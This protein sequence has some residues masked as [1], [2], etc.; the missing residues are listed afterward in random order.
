MPKA[1]VPFP[2]TVTA[3]EAF[4]SQVGAYRGTVYFTSSDTA[5]LPP[6]YT[7]TSTDG[8]PQTVTA[9]D[10][11]HAAV[12]G[13]GHVPAQAAAAFDSLALNGFGGG[14]WTRSR[15]DAFFTEEQRELGGAFI[16]RR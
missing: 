2:L 9:T 13:T 5:A 12:T 8:S 1:G 14:N 4:N 16:G 7:F 10:K 15:L 11:V 6:G 3:L